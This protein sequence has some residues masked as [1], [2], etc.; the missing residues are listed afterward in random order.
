LQTIEVAQVIS[1][2]RRIHRLQE[3]S[4]RGKRSQLIVACTTEC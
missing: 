3:E 2:G 4:G 1:S